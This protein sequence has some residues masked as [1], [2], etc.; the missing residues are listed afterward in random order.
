MNS[1]LL[2]S[3]HC[4]AAKNYSPE[5][6]ASKPNVW[7]LQ[8]QRLK[9]PNVMNITFTLIVTTTFSPNRL[10][11][12]IFCFIFAGDYLSENSIEMATDKVAY[13]LDIADYDLE[14]AKTLYNGGRWL[15]VAFMCHQV[16]EKTLKAYWCGTKET[17]PPYTHNLTR[18]SEGSGLDDQL[19]EEQLDLIETLI[20]MN[21]QAR[22]PDYKEQLARMLTKDTCSNII[23]ET[24]KLQQW[25]K[26][27]LLNSSAN[28]S[29]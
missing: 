27:K 29:N 3:A 19:S 21:I 4:V 28:T 14:T 23:N 26:T 20:P 10:A 16:I 24:E 12:R 17:E 2:F 13:W 1:P 8:T 6:E 5:F 18:L 9:A 22:Y 25:I 15:Y 7:S 11:V